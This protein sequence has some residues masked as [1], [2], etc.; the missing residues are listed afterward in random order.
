MNAFAEVAASNLE[1]LKPENLGIPPRRHKAAH[2][3]NAV[4]VSNKTNDLAMPSVPPDLVVSF[5]IYNPVQRTTISATISALGSQTL[6]ELL[7][8]FADVGCAAER[9]ELEEVPLEN[10]LQTETPPTSIGRYMFFGNAFYTDELIGEARAQTI[11]TWAHSDPNRVL[12]FPHLRFPQM[13]ASTVP[14][15]APTLG[16]SKRTRVAIKPS[17]LSTQSAHIRLDELSVRLHEP[18]L[19]AHGVGACCEHMMTVEEIRLLARS[20]PPPGT[21]S[22]WPKTTFLAMPFSHS[23][24][25]GCASSHIAWITAD[26]E[27]APQGVSAWCDSCYKGFHFDGEGNLAW[28][29][30]KRWR[31]KGKGVTE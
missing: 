13:A 25:V 14:G 17:D 21:P 24:C 20:D 28:K 19:F 12:F 5:N 6:D 10:E 31:V 8:Y 4:A 23:H 7:P 22:Q 9:V 11:I 29:G 2:R 27:Y 18:Y 16:R 3:Q 30:Y 1:T 15:Q 26:D